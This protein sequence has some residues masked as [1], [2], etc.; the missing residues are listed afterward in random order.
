MKI[1]DNKW[2]I[3]T[4]MTQTSGQIVQ[5]STAYPDAGSYLYEEENMMYRIMEKDY[6]RSMDDHL[7]IVWQ[8]DDVKEAEKPETWAK[9]NPLMNLNQEKHDTMLKNLI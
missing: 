3:T 7:C 2:K 8:Q 1:K 5:I 9:S 4:G 6:D